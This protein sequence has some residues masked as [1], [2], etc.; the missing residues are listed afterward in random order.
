M[1][2]LVAAVRAA[3]VSRNPYAALVTA[4]TLP[5]ACAAMEAADGKTSG[6]RYAAWWERYAVAG[7]THK[8]DDPNKAP[9]VYVTGGDAYAL[10]CAVLHEASDSLVGQRA[11]QNVEHF[12]FVQ[13][14]NPKANFGTSTGEG[15]VVLHV[16]RFTEEVCLGVER[17]LEDVKGNDVV[18]ERLRVS[19]YIDDVPD[20]RLTIPWPE[21]DG[22]R[23]GR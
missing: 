18:Q 22:W 19:L 3:N 6:K 8:W 13:P 21:G 11:R 2:E 15:F 1:R 9:E 20:N 12:R 23:S 16:D 10:R 14:A 17:W 7:F 5:D 4:V